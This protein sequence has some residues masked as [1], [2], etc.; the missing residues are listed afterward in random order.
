MSFHSIIEF[1]RVPSS[2]RTISNIWINDDIRPLP[3]HRRTW[4]RWAYVSFWAINQICISNWQL[5]ASLVSAG[6]SVWQAVVA[7]IIGKFIIAA[8]AVFNGYVGAEWHIG[9]YVWGVYGQYIALLQR[10]VLSLVW[11]AVQ[12]WTGGLCV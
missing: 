11:F 1:L 12:S 6:I 7:I 9:R 8:V 3:P 4:K 5:G 10:L 2:S